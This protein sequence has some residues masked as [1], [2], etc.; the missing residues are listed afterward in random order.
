MK[1][2]KFNVI[3]NEDEKIGFGKG[4]YIIFED[5]EGKPM[6]DHYYSIGTNKEWHDLE[7]VSV[8]II[9]NIKNMINIGYEF[10]IYSYNH[11]T[12]EEIF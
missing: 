11:K 6:M 8:D 12:L 5:H 3:W 10:D 2:P 4:Y 1:K 9:S 7:V